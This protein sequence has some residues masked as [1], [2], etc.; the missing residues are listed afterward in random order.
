MTFPVGKF[1]DSSIPSSWVRFSHGDTNVLKQ[2]CRQRTL[3]P[4]L[5]RAVEAVKTSS[6]QIVIILNPSHTRASKM[7]LT[8]HNHNKP[9]VWTEFL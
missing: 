8:W 3:I 7:G 6:N 9:K 5:R 1:G 2:R 4:V